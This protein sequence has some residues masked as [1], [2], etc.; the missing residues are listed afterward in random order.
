V[1]LFDSTLCTATTNYAA[2]QNAWYLELATATC[3]YNRTPN[4]ATGFAPFELVLSRA[5]VPLEAEMDY[6]F[7]DVASAPSPVEFRIAFLQRVSK[8]AEKIRESLIKTQARYKRL[9]DAHVRARTADLCV[10][11]SV[12]VRAYVTEP[13][14]SPKLEFPVTDPYVLTDMTVTHCTV[15]TKEGPLKVHR[16]RV[17]RLPPPEALPSP[18]DWVHPRRGEP[19]LLFQ[20]KKKKNLLS[21]KFRIMALM[22]KVGCSSRYAGMD[23]IPRL[24]HG[25]L[26]PTFLGP[27]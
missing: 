21:R 22:I 3:A 17:F 2:T 24:T 5:P 8:L 23:A 7:I 14:R 13:G 25:S 12:A 10:R 11:D 16:D 18:I 9:Y 20:S 15:R 6:E 4:Q 26:S 27:S 1:E 19:L